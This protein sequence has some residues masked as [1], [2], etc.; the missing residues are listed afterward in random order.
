M[1]NY[2][3]WNFHIITNTNLI[4]V[5]CFKNEEFS[6]CCVSLCVRKDLNMEHN[7]F[8][9]KTLNELVSQFLYLRLNSVG[10]SV[11]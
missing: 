7:L 8:S 3:I 5:L 10:T 1:Q 2:K 11:Y 6:N 4:S 9:P